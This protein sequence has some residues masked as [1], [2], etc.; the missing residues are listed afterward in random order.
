ME[1]YILSP[2][3]DEE[4]ALVAYDTVGMIDE[5]ESVLWQKKYNDAGQCEIYVPCSAEMF[6]LLS[7]GNY[8]FRYDDDMFF[9]IETPEITTD[10]ENGDY[11]I[12]TANDIAKVILSG[13]IVRWNV[14]YSGTVLGFLEKLVNENV[15]SPS[16]SQRRISNFS[17]YEMTA[18]ERAEFTERIEVTAFTNDLYE[19]IKTTCKTFGYGFRVSYNIET[20]KL[21]FRVFKGKNKASESG[22]EYIE[23]SPTFANI[24]TSHYKEDESNYKNVAYVSYKAEDETVHLL[25]VYD[26]QSDGLPEPQGETRKEVHVDAT[27]TSRDITV[28]ELEL[29][30]GTVTKDTETVTE[31]GKQKYYSVYSAN[32]EAVATSWQ[33]VPTGD[34]ETEEK[35][36]VTDYTYLILIRNA[37]VNALEQ[38]RRTQEFTG[39]VD[40]TDTYEYKQDYDIGDIVKVKNEYGISVEA[41]ISEIMESEDNED[42]RT[43]E[44]VFEYLS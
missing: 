35:I 36:T 19:L 16:Q 1:L 26:G 28:E 43:V 13:R 22:S 34:E 9:K 6:A 25:S 39:E 29:M 32:G 31:E 44:P 23:F 21:V 15:I 2:R 7:R 33:D 5:A 17:L 42:G 38:H 41:R 37:G 40:T 24:L 10:V 11:I 8:V 27:G 12:S 3:Y 18:E 14:V 20:Q 30:F 4:G